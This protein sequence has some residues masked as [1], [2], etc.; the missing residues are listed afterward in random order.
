MVL[1]FGRH[2]AKQYIKNISIYFGYKNWIAATCQCCCIQFD[3]YLE[4]GTNS[5]S[6]LGLRVQL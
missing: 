4:A 5:N 2:G 6:V 3:P 1:D